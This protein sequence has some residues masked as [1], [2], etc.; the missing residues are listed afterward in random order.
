MVAKYAFVALKSGGRCPACAH[1]DKVTGYIVCEYT[2]Y[3]NKS[4]QLFKVGGNFKVEVKQ[5]K[6]CVYRPA[7]VE[8]WVGRHES[9]SHLPSAEWS[10]RV[11]AYRSGQIGRVDIVDI[12]IYGIVLLDTVG[13]S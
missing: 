9:E 5:P 8:R 12:G 1:G 11:M 4:E 2:V 10:R 7:A 6:S 3:I 13:N